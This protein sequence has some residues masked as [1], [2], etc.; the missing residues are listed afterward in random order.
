MEKRE[1]L[2]TSEAQQRIQQYG[3]NEIIEKKENPFIKFLKYFWGPIPWMIEAAAIGSAIIKHWADF[4]IISALL[5][6]N[7]IVG[8]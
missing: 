1:G 2:T 4:W 6:L 7:A 3:Y 5:L 8:Y